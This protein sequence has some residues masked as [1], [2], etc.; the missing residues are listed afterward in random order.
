MAEHARPEVFGLHTY[1]ASTSATLREALGRVIRYLHLV[2][3]Y[4]SYSL[5]DERDTARLIVSAPA[6]SPTV[7]WQWNVAV[8]HFFIRA[9]VA[10]EWRLLEAAFPFPAPSEPVAREYARVFQA[11]V[12][13]SAR[14]AGLRFARALLD[15]PRRNRDDRLCQA[16]EQLAR[17]QLEARR[18]SDLASDLVRVELLKLPADHEV[19]LEPIAGRLGMSRRT[20]QRRLEREGGSLRRIVDEVRF[21]R[22]RGYLSFDRLSLAEVGFL[23]GFAEPGAFTRAFIRWSGKTPQAYR[24]AATL[25]RPPASA[26]DGR[27]AERPP[28]RQRSRP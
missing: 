6:G 16:L 28:R 10:A 21:E 1:L 22:A 11:P 3:D 14:H 25:G 17:D 15:A 19:R 2:A 26:A 24:R 13:F 18:S 20:L 27:G 7:T 4:V 23:I 5:K 8:N 12:R 9:L